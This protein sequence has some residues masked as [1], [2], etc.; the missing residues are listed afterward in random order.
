VN[1]VVQKNCLKNSRF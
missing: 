1:T